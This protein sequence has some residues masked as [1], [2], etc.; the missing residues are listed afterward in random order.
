MKVK[1]GHNNM[2]CLAMNLGSLAWLVQL[3]WLKISNRPLKYGGAIYNPFWF[4]GVF[5]HAREIF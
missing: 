4:V 2:S 3:V 1:Q 5:L